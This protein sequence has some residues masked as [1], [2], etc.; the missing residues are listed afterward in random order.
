M[1]ASTVLLEHKIRVLLCLKLSFP[2]NSEGGI[3]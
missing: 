1:V 3:D 2:K